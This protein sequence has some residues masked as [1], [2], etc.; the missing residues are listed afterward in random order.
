MDVSFSLS[1]QLPN[2]EELHCLAFL[3]RV[4]DPCGQ[5]PVHREVGTLSEGYSGPLRAES[6]GG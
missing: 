6:D 4:Q 5:S 3:T 2:G 1:L